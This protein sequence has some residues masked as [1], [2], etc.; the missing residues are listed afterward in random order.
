MDEFNFLGSEVWFKD[1]PYWA[2]PI[3]NFDSS[4]APKGK[5]LAGFV[6]VMDENKSENSI[7][8][9]AYDTIYRALPYIEKHIEMQHEQITILQK[10]AVTI[11]GK[12]ADI[13]TPI[14]NLYL[15]GTDT[16][17]RSMGVTRA[18]YS[19]IEMLGAL[20]EDG[21]LH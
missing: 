1:A 12:I 17:S 3:S 10:A 18:A 14:K 6:F 4:L 9:N 15:A 7:I 13:R 21:N 11:D 20:N 16:V 2:M 5:Q 8:K 19:I